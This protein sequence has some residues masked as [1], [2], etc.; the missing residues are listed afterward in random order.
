MYERLNR[1]TGSSLAY[2]ITR[3]LGREEMQ[4][5]TDELEG[6]ISVHGRIRVLIDL[7]AFPFDGLGSLWEELKFD[8]RHTPRLERLA[9]VGGTDVQQ[10]VSRIF[11]VLTHTRCH[12]F[13]EGELDRAWDW[14]TGD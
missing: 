13:N 6:T 14:L 11:G 9:I 8:I 2:R 7:K 10:W 5:I 12:C 4:Q 3:P 1:S